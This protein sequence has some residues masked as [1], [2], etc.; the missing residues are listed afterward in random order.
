MESR[1]SLS[2]DGPEHEVEGHHKNEKE[3]GNGERLKIHEVIARSDFKA[4]LW[5]SEDS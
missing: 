5:A 2:P 1:L 4:A 3:N